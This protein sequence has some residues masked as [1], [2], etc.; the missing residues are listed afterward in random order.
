M[1]RIAITSTI[2]I[3]PSELEEHFTRA[4]GPGGQNV[5]KVATA[6][7]LRFDVRHSPS[8]PNWMSIRAQAIAGKR[9]TKDGV[10]VIDAHNHRSQEQNREEALKRLVDLLKDAAHRPA[11]RRPTQ[12][13]RASKEKRVK[14]KTQRGAVKKLRKVRLEE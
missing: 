13:S 1:D 4:P 3:D 6:V 11:R 2:S 10:I 14:A 8:L 12:P 7:Q 9:L 5:N